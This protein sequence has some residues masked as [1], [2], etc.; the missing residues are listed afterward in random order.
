MLLKSDDIKRIEIDFDS[1]MLPPPFSHVFKLKISFEKGFINTQFTVHYTDRDELTED[2]IFSEGFTQDDDY[3]F[4]GEVPKVWEQPLISLYAQTKWS[5]KRE[6]DENGGIKVFAKD[7]HGKISRSIPM[8]QEEWHMLAQEFIQAIYEI[9]QKEAPLTIRYKSITKETVD[10]YALTVKFSVRKVIIEK[11]GEITEW[12][13]DESRQLLSYIYLPDYDYEVASDSPPKKRGQY[14]DCGDGFWHKFGKGVN[15]LD[16]SF[17]A[18]S[19][20]QEGF[21]NLNQK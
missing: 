3:S 16:E 6:L 19:K 17:D 5:N 11:N 7:T 13:W 4:I 20:I 9:N 1:G 12:N 15:N 21:E 2:E 8:N 18:V 14:I 10:E